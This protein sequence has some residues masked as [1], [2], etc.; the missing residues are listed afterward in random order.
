DAALNVA[1]EVI[2]QAATHDGRID[3]PWMLAVAGAGA[4]LGEA[5]GALGSRAFRSL[6]TAAL[7]AEEFKAGKSLEALAADSSSSGVGK[8]VRF[9]DENQ[10]ISSKPI[11]DVPAESH[12][13]VSSKQVDDQVIELGNG[14]ADLEVRDASVSLSANHNTAAYKPATEDD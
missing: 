9:A 8:Q 5:A 7:S 2:S 14:Q 1:S 13:A 6:K 11:A 3:Q 10:V 4:L 12:V